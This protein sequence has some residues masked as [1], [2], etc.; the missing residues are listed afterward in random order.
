[1]TT[2]SL[3]GD[4]KGIFDQMLLVTSRKNK[5]A[6]SSL[7]PFTGVVWRS[8]SYLEQDLD[9][10]WLARDGGQVQG[11]ASWKEKE[12]EREVGGP[13]HAGDSQGGKARDA[14][15]IRGRLE[16]EAL[17]H[18][19]PEIP[20]SQV[21]GTW[22]GGGKRVRCTRL[23]GRGTPRRMLART[24]EARSRGLRL[25]PPAGASTSPHRCRR[26]KSEQHSPVLGLTHRLRSCC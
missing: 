22:G 3:I 21:P 26:G 9:T 6:L 25:E 8:C 5:K 7:P 17:S 15:I 10:L 1:M 2:S 23:A 20:V 18:T 11:G 12:G 24:Y 4:E 19:G 16:R 13:M 14:Q